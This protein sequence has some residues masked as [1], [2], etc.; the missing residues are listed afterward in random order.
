MNYPPTNK[1][2]ERYVVKATHSDG[3]VGYLFRGGEVEK[4]ADGT[5]WGAP[6]AARNAITVYLMNLPRLEMRTILLDVVDT[7]AAK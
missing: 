6:S 5:H 2:V 4:E 3:R 1:R 7:W